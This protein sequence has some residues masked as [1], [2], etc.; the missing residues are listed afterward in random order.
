MTGPGSTVH[1]LGYF[2][3]LAF[4]FVFGLGSRK[5]DAIGL[6]PALLFVSFGVLCSA[7]ALELYSP[8]STLVDVLAELTLMMVL[9]ADASRIDLAALRREAGLPVRLLGIGMPLTIV[10]GALVAALCFPSLSL[11][12]LALL[13]AVLAPTDAALGQAVV[14]SREVPLAVRQ[15]LNVESGLNDGIALPIVMVCAALAGTE[16][17]PEAAH[18]NWWLFTLAQVGLGPLAGAAVAYFGGK[19][20]QWGCDRGYM[21]GSFE[22]IAGLSLGLLAFVVAQLIGGNGFIAAFVAGLVLGN[23]SRSFANEVHTFVEAEGQLL[24]L[25]VFLLVGVLWVIPTVVSATPLMWIYAIASLTVIRMVPVAL[26]LIGSKARAPTV[27]FLAWFGP[28]GLATVLFALLVAEREA[29]AG[30][31]LVFEVAILT[32]VCSVVAH[33]LSARVGARRYAAFAEA[34]LSEVHMEMAEVTDNPTRLDHARA[35]SARGRG[36]D[37]SGL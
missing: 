30:R 14:S 29:V 35:R 34:R 7:P 16:S 32:V 24:M 20:A 8:S 28:R 18:T 12:E 10:L 4:V 31:E 1:E 27:L 26:S 37:A 15:A 21:G 13:G 6:S 33:G 22:R 25:G 9:Y 19:A 36:A 23:S 3:V 11:W 5:L 17:S 2:I